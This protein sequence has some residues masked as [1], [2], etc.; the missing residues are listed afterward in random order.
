MNP[1]I[2]LL[3][4]TPFIRSGWSRFTY[5][6]LRATSPLF[7]LFGWFAIATLFLP[8][9]LII[10]LLVVIIIGGAVL[11]SQQIQKKQTVHM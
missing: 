5:M 2:L 6:F 3:E 4:A 10:L 9:Y 1:T 7:L 11:L 8:I